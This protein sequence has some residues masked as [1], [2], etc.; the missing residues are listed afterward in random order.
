MKQKA[1]FSHVLVEHAEIHRRLENWAQWCRPGRKRDVSPMFVL[2]RSDNFDRQVRPE[3]K[4]V[5]IPGAL[6]LQQRFKELPEKE[7]LAIAWCYCWGGNNHVWMQS[8]SKPRSPEMGD[9]ERS[10][11]S[12]G[13]AWGIQSAGQRDS[14]PPAAL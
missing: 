3:S 10:P 1:D 8:L 7:R 12:C 11:A 5:D 4:T 14:E 13:R 6:V 9:S 2:Y